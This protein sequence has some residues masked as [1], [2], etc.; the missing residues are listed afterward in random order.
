MPLC[1]YS[2][3]SHMRHVC[4]VLSR[5]NINYFWSTIQQ[6]KSAKN[7]FFYV[8]ETRFREECNALLNFNYFLAICQGKEK[9]L[10]GP[11]RLITCFFFSKYSRD[12]LTPYHSRYTDKN[13][14]QFDSRKSGKTKVYRKISVFIDYKPRW[15]EKERSTRKVGNTTLQVFHHPMSSWNKHDMG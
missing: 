11:S 15:N 3:S 2:F 8:L 12:P 5:W 9:L 7:I 6:T 13:E 10:G 1:I 14:P 4:T